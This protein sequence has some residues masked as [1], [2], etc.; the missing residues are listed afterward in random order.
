MPK[1]KN[2]RAPSG[3]TP[4]RRTSRRGAIEYPKVSNPKIHNNDE[5]LEVEFRALCNL[6]PDGKSSANRK[7]EQKYNY[8]VNNQK[9]NTDDKLFKNY[10]TTYGKHLGKLMSAN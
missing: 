7:L 4:P 3:D 2:K 8:L 1:K 10:S 9:M 5:S 6:K